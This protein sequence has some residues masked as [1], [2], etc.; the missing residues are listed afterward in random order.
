M[1]ITLQKGQSSIT[2]PGPAPGSQAAERRSQ[3]TGR[4]ASG[5][6][7]CYDK[8]VRS[9]TVELAFESLTDQEKA[10]LMSFFDDA[11]NGAME[12]FTYTDS[13]GRTFT[14]RFAGAEL[15]WRKVAQN[16]WDVTFALELDQMAG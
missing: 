10:S 11:A 15:A 9:F 3:V 7:Y 4:A 2:L 14:A 6:L 16:V 8:G 13:G 1:S 12:T 5:Q